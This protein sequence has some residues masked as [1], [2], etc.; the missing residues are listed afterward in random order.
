MPV[1]VD[2]VLTLVFIGFAVFVVSLAGCAVVTVATGDATIEK[3]EGV[4][5]VKPKPKEKD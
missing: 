3:V 5:V 2:G 4:L 1:F